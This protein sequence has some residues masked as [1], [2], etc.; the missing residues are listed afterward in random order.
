MNTLRRTMCR[1]LWLLL[2]ARC[3]AALHDVPGS[4]KEINPPPFADLPHITA[5]VSATLLDGHGGL[6]VTNSVVLVRN[7]GIEKVGVRSSIAIPSG[8][9][10]FD[11]AGLTLVPGLMDSHF[12]IERDYELPRLYLAHGVTSIRDPGQWLEIYEPIKSSALP[13]PRCFVAGPH[14]DSLPHAHPKDAFAVMTAEETRVAINRFVDEGASHIKVYFRLPLELIRVACSAAHARGVPVTAHLELVDADEAIRAGLD[15]IEHVT[16]FGTALAEKSDAEKFREAV[17]ND[18]EARRKARYELWSKLDLDH[19]PRV[20]PLIDL[21]VKEKIFLSPTLA[22]FERRAGDKG[23][24]DV[25]ARGYANMLKFVRL[26]H[27]A[28]ATIVVGSHSSVPKAERGW[29][30]QREMELLVECGLTPRE[31]I[32]AATL[33]NARFFHADARLGSIEAGKLADLVLID[34]DPLA[35]IAAMRQVKRVM[36]NGQWFA[37]PE[38]IG[39]G[40]KIVR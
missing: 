24:T 4:L 31:V 5:I 29:A 2:A 8:A 21:I 6:P 32:T 25:E 11:A 7:G 36:L 37:L 15:G 28:G 9:E 38:E 12:H 39:T 35:D 27:R 13:Q 16:S 1:S 19:S 26:C 33:N 40:R 20:R 17:R 10:V 18:N 3:A 23:V 22:V 34:G 30:Y 14:L